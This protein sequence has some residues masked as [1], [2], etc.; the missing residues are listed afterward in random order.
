MIYVKIELNWKETA[1]TRVTQNIRRR[2]RNLS[3]QY[4][5]LAREYQLV[6]ENFRLIKIHEYHSSTTCSS[7]TLLTRKT[8]AYI[9]DT[10][11]SMTHTGSF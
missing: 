6:V 3:L 10:S 7:S 11:Q 9:L 2:L 1:A 5:I 4:M 8:L